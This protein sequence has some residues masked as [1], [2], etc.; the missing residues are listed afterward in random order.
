MKRIYLLLAFLG[1]TNL[2]SKSIDENNSIESSTLIL[3]KS[4]NNNK[5]KEQYKRIISEDTQKQNSSHG[6]H[7]SHISH[8]SQTMTK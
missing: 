3:E 1:L 6:S 2:Y 4:K 7:Y 8:Y 5:E